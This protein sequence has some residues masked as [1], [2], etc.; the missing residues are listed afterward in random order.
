MIFSQIFNFSLLETQKL[1]LN[2]LSICSKSWKNEKNVGDIGAP[3]NIQN[4]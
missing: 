4:N 1:T 2:Y 3:G